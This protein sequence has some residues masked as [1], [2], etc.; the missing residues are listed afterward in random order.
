MEALAPFY[1][2]TIVD[3]RTQMGSHRAVSTRIARISLAAGAAAVASLALAG[4]ASADPGFLTTQDLTAPKANTFASDIAVS[5]KGD[6]TYVWLRPDAANN[7]RV[8]TRRQLRFKNFLGSLTR[9]LSDAGAAA[10]DA[11]VGVDAKG[12]RTFVWIRNGVVQARRLSI[13]GT[14]GPVVDLSAAAEMPQEADVAVD[15]QGN[16]VFV[17]TGL[18]AGMKRRVRTRRRT[19]GGVLSATQ[20]LDAGG[21]DTQQPKLDVD[22]SGNATFVWNRSNG[23]NQIIQV[24]RRLAGG[25]LSTIKDLSAAG[26]NSFRPTIDVNSQGKAAV[27]WTRFDGDEYVQTRVRSATG[28]L[29]AIQDLTQLVIGKDATGNQ[30]ALDPTG[31]ATYIW[32]RR[33]AANKIPWQTRKRLASGA[34]TATRDLSTDGEGVFTPGVGVDSRGNAVFLFENGRLESRSQTAAGTIGPLEIVAPT[35]TANPQLAINAA[36]DGAGSWNTANRAQGVQ[37][38]GLRSAASGGSST[39]GIGSLVSIKGY[40]L[41]RKRFKAARRGRAVARRGARLGRKVGTRVR[42][43][44]SEDAT[45]RFRIERARKAKGRIVGG[46]CVKRTRANAGR[47]KCTRYR[48]L[49]GKIVRRNKAGVKRFRLSGRLLGKRLRRGRYRLVAR[50]TDKLGNKSKRAR[51]RFRIVR[52]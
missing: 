21:E 31:V 46:R 11:H 4:G 51:V 3:E 22:P 40:R 43:R 10:T 49:K 17:W 23:A 50:A 14:L 6:A 20:E 52:R 1:R 33:N 18:D 27:T 32:R 19:V 42:Y 48:T 39:A 30:V 45:V 37:Y 8:Q 15:P 34:L 13:N 38:E 36:G 41:S 7:A 25:A 9:T 5:P 28:Q 12:S 26:K 44:L 29:S 24:R 16:A 47:R 2:H 35:G